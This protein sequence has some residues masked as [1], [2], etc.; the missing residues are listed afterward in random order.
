MR[1]SVREM[2]EDPHFRARQLFERVEIDGKTLEIPALFPRLA[3]TP[4]ATEWA[5]AGIGS[6]TDEVLREV[7]GLDGGEIAALRDAAVI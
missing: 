3:D 2:F 5:G 6:H 4:G 1:N 7:L